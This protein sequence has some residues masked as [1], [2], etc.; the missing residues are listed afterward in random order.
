MNN[1]E[2]FEQYDAGGDYVGNL[3]KPPVMT[4]R[5]KMDE[6]FLRWKFREQWPDVTNKWWMLMLVSEV[7][8]LVKAIMEDDSKKLEEV[9]VRVG[10]VAMYWADRLDASDSP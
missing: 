9:L 8:S 1:Q 2:K 7:N 3:M 5:Q 10:A 6:L 4:V